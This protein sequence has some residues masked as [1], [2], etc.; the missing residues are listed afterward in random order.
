LATTAAVICTRKASNGM[1]RHVS[2]RLS[3]RW[4]VGVVSA[5]TSLSRFSSRGTVRPRA[6]AEHLGHLCS[7]CSGGATHSVLGRI[8]RRG[9]RFAEARHGVLRATP[10]RAL[11]LCLHRLRRQER[12][13]GCE[14]VRNALARTLHALGVSEAAAAAAGATGASSWAAARASSGAAAAASGQVAPRPGPPAAQRRAAAMRCCACTS[15]ICNA[16]W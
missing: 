1:L 4:C 2:E 12:T 9:V 13:L 11:E 6:K 16:R 15:V 8:L 3:W 14:H 5:T 7:H 10:L